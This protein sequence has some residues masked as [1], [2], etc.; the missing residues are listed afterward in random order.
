MIFRDPE[1]AL[2]WAYETSARP[3]VKSSGVYGMRGAERGGASELKPYDYIAQAGLIKLLCERAL[4]P[5]H[6]AYVEVRYGRNPARLGPLRCYVASRLGTGIHS[7]RCIDLVIRGYC[8]EQVAMRDML[9]AGRC[10]YRTVIEVRNRCH[11]DLDAIH[12]K[13]ME[14]LWREMDEA[15]MMSTEHI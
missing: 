10:R 1:T 6:L 5:L 3:V 13:T 14:L 2:R 12:Q 7:V 9:K 4:S 11:D 8:G 15:K